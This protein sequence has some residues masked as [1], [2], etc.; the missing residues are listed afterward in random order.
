[1]LDFISKGSVGLNGRESSEKFKKKYMSPPGIEPATLGLSAG[2][3]DS[4][5]IGIVIYLRLTLSE[6]CHE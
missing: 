6:S 5:A 1:M 3:P 2:H 4:L